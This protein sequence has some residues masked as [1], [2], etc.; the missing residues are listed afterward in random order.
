MI[1]IRMRDIFGIVGLKL[2]GKDIH[3]Q[4]DVLCMCE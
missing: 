3:C 1:K 2:R 4:C